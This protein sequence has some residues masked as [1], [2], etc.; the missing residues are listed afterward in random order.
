MV[1]IAHHHEEASMCSGWPYMAVVLAAGIAGEQGVVNIKLMLRVQ[2][3][4]ARHLHLHVIE[5]VV[6]G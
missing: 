6:S 3:G 4:L 5:F 1:R 2:G